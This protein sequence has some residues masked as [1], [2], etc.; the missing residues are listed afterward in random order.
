MGG[1]AAELFHFDFFTS[2]CLNY[3]WAGDKH[4]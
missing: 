1:S 3:I 4:M 2:D